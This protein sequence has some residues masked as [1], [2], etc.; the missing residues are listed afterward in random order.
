VSETTSVRRSLG[1][2]TLTRIA[3]FALGL[4]TVVIVSRMLTPEEIGVFSVSVALIGFANLLREFGVGQYLINVK[5]VTREVRRAA[6]T[7]TLGISWSIA[8]SLYFLKDIAA[9]FYREPRMEQVMALLAVNFLV[10]P[11]A[12]PLRAVLQRDMQFA[13]LAIVDLSNSF[14]AAVATIVAA[15]LGASSLSM[16]WGSILGNVMGFVALFVISPRG[17]VDWPTTKGLR[18]VF[19]FGSRY[20]VASFTTE[21]G[22][23]APDL[24]LGRTLGFA[25]VAYFSR[26]NGVL[27][28]ALGQVRRIVGAVYSPVLARCFREKQDLPALY[29]QFN[30]MFLSI[31][32]PAAGL[33]AL[34]S[35]PLMDFMFGPQWS[36][37]APLATML[38]VFFMLQAP[39]LLAPT[40]LVATGNVGLMMRCRLV[41]ECVRVAL[42]LSSAIAPLEAVVALLGIAYLV[43]GLIFTWA[44]RARLGIGVRLF[45]AS[46]GGCYGLVPM[47]VAV[48]AVVL[49]LLQ[50]Q[51]VLASALQIGI[52]GTTGLVCWYGSLRWLGHPMAGEVHNVVG[53]V[54][55][56]IGG[57]RSPSK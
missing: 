37:S 52:V 20:S 10:L 11:F 38:C 41:L 53:K 33:L 18:E 14:T 56:S 17:A 25:D 50:R 30:R 21:I 22:V 46:I 4:L 42:L 55:R 2:V 47:T 19:R 3:G 6:F 39:V 40:T 54:M 49:W 51:G 36:R 45:W 8:V 34:L 26:A 7:V 32:L 23:A 15:W 48:P 1:V 29:L 31:V 44:L 57:L 5:E 24:V 13:K 16:A 12:T 35:A 27:S 9:A 43:E 28:M